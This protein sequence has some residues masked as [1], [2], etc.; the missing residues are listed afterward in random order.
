MPERGTRESSVEDCAELRTR[1][2]LFRQQLAAALLANPPSNPA[3]RPPLSRLE[4]LRG[5][6]SGSTAWV[7]NPDI[8]LH[9]K[10][11]SA[12]SSDGGSP[13]IDSI[14]G[15]VL[16][17]ME[18]AGDPA[19]WLEPTEPVIIAGGSVRVGLFDWTTNRD[20]FI[21]ALLGRP[22]PAGPKYERRGLRLPARLTDDFDIVREQLGARLDD[23]IALFGMSGT[24]A[25][26][27]V[28]PIGRVA[29]ATAG[30]DSV[31]VAVQS[32]VVA[33]DPEGFAASP[34]G[35]IALGI[36][37]SAPRWRTPRVDL[38]LATVY[39]LGLAGHLGLT[40]W[41]GAFQLR[42]YRAAMAAHL[43]CLFDFQVAPQ[44][45]WRDTRTR[46]EALAIWILPRLV[47]LAEPGGVLTRP[48]IARALRREN[49]AEYD[50]EDEAVTVRRL[51]RLSGKLN[52]GHDLRPAQSRDEAGR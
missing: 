15:M 16:R 40:F 28:G 2:K 30:T 43:R 17:S 8:A 12:L 9:P 27:E 44:N 32:A 1:G 35:R 48:K 3:C 23:S 26:R 20:D 22:V 13:L 50:D 47:G 25:A 31:R 36:I 49:P 42:P 34:A 51:Y 39:D 33:I 4:R 24:E 6:L 7:S 21:E 45:R 10:V 19:R 5:S 52:G 37:R 11:L 46:R 38:E 18:R 14:A 41:S 29:V